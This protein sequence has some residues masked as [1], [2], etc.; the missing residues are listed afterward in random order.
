ML[1]RISIGCRILLPACCGIVRVRV[2]TCAHTATR[3]GL[4]HENLCA[5]CASTL[6]VTAPQPQRHPNHLH[7]SPSLASTNFH[8]ASLAIA[9]SLARDDAGNIRELHTKASGLSH[10]FRDA[11]GGSGGSQPYVSSSDY[12]PSRTY[13][14]GAF[15]QMAA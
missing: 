4:K 8:V 12:Y 1:W 15:Q 14:P 9:M 10:N 11:S 5:S 7:A 6:P 2:C 13:K 3:S